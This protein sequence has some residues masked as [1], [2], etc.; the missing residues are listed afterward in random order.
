MAI[1]SEDQPDKSDKRPVEG[2]A[3]HRY[4]VP[5]EML[6]RMRR[7]R[8]KVIPEGDWQRYINTI[9]NLKPLSNNWISGGWGLTGVAV[10]LGGIAIA[11][12]AQALMFGGFALL[13]AM[14]AVICF[15]ADRDVN[16]G[17][18]TAA[19]EIA[20]EM[21]ERDVDK[22]EYIPLEPEEE[23]PSTET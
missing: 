19:Q 20:K 6:L 23:F 1:Y 8:G 7:E 10:S 14:G 13:C 2:Q 12:A 21:E 4:A 3:T 11:D 18:R 9:R 15:I 17:R 5:K 22:I 16:G